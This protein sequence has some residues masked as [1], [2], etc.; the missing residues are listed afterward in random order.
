MSKKNQVAKH[1]LTFVQLPNG[2]VGINDPDTEVK[3][4]PKIPPVIEQPTDLKTATLVEFQQ[5]LLTLYALIAKYKM[6][7]GGS[8]GYKRGTT[9]K[10]VKF[11]YGDTETIKKRLKE[12]ER[13]A[14]RAYTLLIK[15][16][17]DHDFDIE[18]EYDYE[19]IFKMLLDRDRRDRWKAVTKKLLKPVTFAELEV[20]FLAWYQTKKRR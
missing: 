3:A 19:R 7:R 10:M 8:R 18:G 12:Q 13:A 9:E 11:Y 6:T 17:N 14:H 5:K 16:C 4:E 1:Q 15:W 2:E 20:D